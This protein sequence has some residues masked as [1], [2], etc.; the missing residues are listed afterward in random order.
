MRKQAGERGQST[1][2][3]VI[4]FT[5]IAAAIIFAAVT[6]IRPAVNKTY[7]QAGGRIEAGADYFGNKVGLGFR[8]YDGGD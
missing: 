4:V 8:G 7:N 6:I 3:Y 5:A 1:V 2:E